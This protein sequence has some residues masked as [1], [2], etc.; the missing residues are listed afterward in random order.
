MLRAARRYDVTT[1]SIVF[2]NNYPY[3]K[4]AYNMA[5]MVPAITDALFRFC[6]Y[7]SSLKVDNAEY[8]L[9]T[10]IVLFSG[11]ILIS[12]NSLEYFDLLGYSC[13]SGNLCLILFCV[14]SGSK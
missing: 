1:D 3:K 12:P 8:A 9:L 5:G 11:E 14:C 6:G 7:M 10:A 13:V 2:G 4:E